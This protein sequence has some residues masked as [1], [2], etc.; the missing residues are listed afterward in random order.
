MSF[1]TT[2]APDGLT[3][4]ARFVGAELILIAA[5]TTAPDAPCPA[6]RTPSTH[7]HSH[8]LRT[9]ADLPTHGHRVVWLVTARR[10]RCRHSG[11]P[12]LIFCE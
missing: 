10:V 1:S 12:C 3:I 6:R 7:V 5:V 2:V 11:C 4:T 8:Y 9:V